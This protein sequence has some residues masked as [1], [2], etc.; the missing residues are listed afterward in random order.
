MMMNPYNY[1]FF[2]DGW[3]LGG[4][5]MLFFGAVLVAGVVLIV[6]WAIRAGAS[7]GRGEQSAG[8]LSSDES[9]AI[10]RR[11]YAAGEITKEQYDDL[12]KALGG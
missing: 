6:V 11:R 1:G 10:V 7:H 5:A 9:I 4:L 12:L 3:L 2:N 8:S